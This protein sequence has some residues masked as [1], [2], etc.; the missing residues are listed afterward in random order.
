MFYF[1]QNWPYRPMPM[2]IMPSV[3]STIWILYFENV[4]TTWVYMIQWTLGGSFLGPQ[5]LEK[6]AETPVKQDE[7]W[8]EFIFNLFFILNKKM[9]VRTDAMVHLLKG[10][11][12]VYR[13]KTETIA[14]PLSIFQLETETLSTVLSSIHWEYLSFHL[15]KLR[16]NQRLSVFFS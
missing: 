9:K 13:V 7:N 15:L 11:V 3:L 16:P 14:M 2:C 5:N 4:T 12:S 10:Y 1:Q 6:A 8:W